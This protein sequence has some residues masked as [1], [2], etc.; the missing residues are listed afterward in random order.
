V[1]QCNRDE[2]IGATIDD[3]LTADDGYQQLDSTGKLR[4]EPVWLLPEDLPGSQAIVRTLHDHILSGSRKVKSNDGKEESFIDK[5]E[6]HL[7]LA[8]TYDNLASTV[9]ASAALRVDY[10]DCEGMEDEDYQEGEVLL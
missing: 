3:L 2:Q 10:D 7:L 1:I 5:V 4:T 9:A 8:A 6:N